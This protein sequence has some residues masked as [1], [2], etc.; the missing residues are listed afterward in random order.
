MPIAN[1]TGLKWGTL[2]DG[3]KLTMGGQ[4][5]WPVQW[6]HHKT[7]LMCEG[8]CISQVYLRF[9][10][11]R[12]CKVYL[13]AT[14]SLFWG[15]LST[16]LNIVLEDRSQVGHREF[17][18]LT[19]QIGYKTFTSFTHLRISPYAL[20]SSFLCLS[21]KVNARVKVPRSLMIR[22]HM[23]SQGCSA[24]GLGWCTLNEIVS[25]CAYKQ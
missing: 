4:V 19:V 10:F 11:Q 12:R 18:P 6:T 1:A 7:T 17:L 22:L 20:H 24:K 21:N 8:L 14:A 13:P 3:C 25:I 15:R 2:S 23:L 9:I 16:Y 5:G